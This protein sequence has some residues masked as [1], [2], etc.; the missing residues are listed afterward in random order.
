LRDHPDEVKWA[1][2]I[3][4]RID[5]RTHEGTGL[6]TRADRSIEPE[7]GPGDGRPSRLPRARRPDDASLESRN[8]YPVRRPRRLPVT[9]AVLRPSGTTTAEPWQPPPGRERPV[10]ER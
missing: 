4:E 6:A 10:L 2:Q 8:E 9:E 7:A 5:A 1:R 3:G